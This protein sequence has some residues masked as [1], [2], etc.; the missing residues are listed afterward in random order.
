VINMIVFFVPYPRDSV[1]LL[2]PDYSSGFTLDAVTDLTRRGTT[3][4]QGATQGSVRTP[5]L[6]ISEVYIHRLQDPHSSSSTQLNLASAAFHE[7]MHNQL[8][9]DDGLHSGDGFARS[10]PSGNTPSA[11]S[12]SAM[13]SKIG[14]RTPQWQDGFAVWLKWNKDRQK[15]AGHHPLILCIVCESGCNSMPE[16][17]ATRSFNC[18]VVVPQ[19]RRGSVRPHRQSSQPGAVRP[20]GALPATP[21]RWHL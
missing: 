20:G 21:L 1:I 13:A 19:H 4:T 3:V 5:T 8:G 15:S 18:R 6:G 16:K 12:V 9:M 17:A 2:H 14:T 7:S 11:A 10:V